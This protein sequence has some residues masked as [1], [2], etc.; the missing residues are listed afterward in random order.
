MHAKSLQSCPTLCDPMDCS[1]LGSSVHGILQAEY[2][3][4]LPC[5]PPGDLL[6]P[7]IEPMSLNIS[8]I[9][10]RVLYHQ[11]HLGRPKNWGA[12]RLRRWQVRASKYKAHT[13]LLLSVLFVSHAPFLWTSL[14]GQMDFF[15]QRAGLAHFA[16]LPII[17]L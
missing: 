8:C 5:P 11:N 16:D 1:P 14:E 9:S 10:R 6:D 7:R 17:Y 12:G 2:W 3:S 13:D 4:G 15:Q